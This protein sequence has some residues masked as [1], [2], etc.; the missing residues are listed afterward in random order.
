MHQTL[1]TIFVW[2]KSSD[3]SMHV[4]DH[5]VICALKTSKCFVLVPSN[6]MLWL[7]EHYGGLDG[8]WKKV[9]HS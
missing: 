7:R 8:Q 1:T 4:E 5:L 2:T 6:R 9:L 3:N